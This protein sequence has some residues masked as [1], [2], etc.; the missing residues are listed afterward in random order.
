[1]ELYDIFIQNLAI[2]LPSSASILGIGAVAGGA[3]YKILKAAERI[4]DVKEIR[5]LTE[6]V[7]RAEAR[8]EAMEAVIKLQVD[9]M[10]RIQGYTDAKLQG[11]GADGKK[12]N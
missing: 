3:I 11:G 1:M 5:D 10:A 8:M 4:K 12:Q 7:A 2:W 9:T 6:A